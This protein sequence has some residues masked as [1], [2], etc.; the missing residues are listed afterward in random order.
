MCGFISLIIQS[1][2]D[3]NDSDENLVPGYSYFP[4]QVGDSLIYDVQVYDKDLNEVDSSYQLLERVESAFEDNEGRPTFRLE[5][6]VR[7]DESAPWSIFKVW[8]A[9]LTISSAEKKEDNVIYI[10]LVFPLKDNVEWNG[11]NKNIYANDDDLEDYRMTSLN[12]PLSLGTLSFDSSL[13]VTQ[14][15]LDNILDSRYYIEK[16]AAGIGMVYKEQTDSL[17]NNSGYKMKI[18]KYVETLIYSNK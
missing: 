5:R 9:N 16:Y 4:M 10:K 7:T 6:Y 17:Q 1:C 12:V 2:K 14:L 8:T 3:T 15:N 18:H 13:T 11:N